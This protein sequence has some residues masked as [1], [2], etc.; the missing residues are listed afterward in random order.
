[1]LR[2]VGKAHDLSAGLVIGGKSYEI[3]A[4]AISMMNILVGTPGRIVHH[5]ENTAMF[6]CDSLSI[7]VLDEADRCLDMGFKTSLTAIIDALPVSRQTLLFSATQTKS[8]DDLAVLSLKSPQIVAVHDKNE[9]STPVRLTQSYT[10]L[11]AE[12]KFDFLLSFLRNHTKAKMICFLTSCKQVRFMFEMFRRLQPGIPLMHLHG[13]MSQERRL[14]IFSD[15]NKRTSSCLFCTDLVARGLD[16]EHV[17]WVVQFDCPESTDTYIHRVG[18]TARFKNSG[19]S[20]LMLLPSEVV[21][22]QELPLKKVQAKAD[23]LK[24]SVSGKFQS[25]LAEDA[26]LKY[27]AQK[28]FVTYVRSVHLQSRKDIFKLDEIDLSAFAAAMGLAGVPHVVA[29]QSRNQTKSWKNM[30]VALRNLVAEPSEETTKAA[31][32]PDKVS[33]LLARKNTT[34]FDES[35]DRLRLEEASEQED[36]DDDSELLR[37]KQDALIDLD[38]EELTLRAKRA[39]SSLVF[40]LLILSARRSQTFS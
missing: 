28:A 37:V 35:R 11:A 25:L 6:N 27:L 29:N 33:R 34:V 16:F 31:D 15:F 1:V 38:D 24:F 17:D 9:A 10:I 39:V 32:R 4:K 26:D 13:R 12:S 8:V 2:K 20:L 7:L 14:H 30:P 40:Q 19:K 22:I 5:L 3:E 21:M 36:N 18:R 23:K